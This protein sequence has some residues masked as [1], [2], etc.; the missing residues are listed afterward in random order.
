MRKGEVRDLKKRKKKTWRK[1]G[2]LERERKRKI[3]NKILRKR[4]MRQRG[5]VDRKRKKEKET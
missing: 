4:W 1:D 5:R 3:G 2:G